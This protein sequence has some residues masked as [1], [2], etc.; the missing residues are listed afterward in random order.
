MIFDLILVF[1][2]IHGF[3]C[4]NLDDFYS[5]ASNN[6]SSRGHPFRL[7]IPINRNN[8]CHFN[9][10]SRVILVWNSLPDILVFSTKPHFVQEGIN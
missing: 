9:F 10:S 8:T 6:R 4:L 2:I 5:F 1:K 7:Y 3:I